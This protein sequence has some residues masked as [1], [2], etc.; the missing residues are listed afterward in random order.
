MNDYIPVYRYKPLCHFISTDV[1]PHILTVLGQ[2]SI[3]LF[4]R[5]DS[6]EL[7]S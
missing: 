1:A 3:L 5:A 7:F 2:T 6:N 4:F